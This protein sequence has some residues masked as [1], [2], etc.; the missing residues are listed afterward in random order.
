VKPCRALA[1]LRVQ[2][3]CNWAHQFLI[4]Y[5]PRRSVG[6]CQSGFFC[7]LEVWVHLVGCIDIQGEL[8][9][10]GAFLGVAPGHEKELTPCLSPTLQFA[11][12]SP[13]TNLSNCK[14]N[15]AAIWRVLPR[16]ENGGARM[17]CQVL[18]YPGCGSRQPNHPAAGAGRL[19]QA[20]VRRLQS[21]ALFLIIKSCYL[22]SNLTASSTFHPSGLLGEV[23]CGR[24]SF[25]AT[26]ASFP[27]PVFS[28]SGP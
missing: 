4:R 12:P 21:P 1:E 9:T 14:V 7:C 8:G 17:V 20:P 13:G 28:P 25:H 2:Q 3:A 24:P 5:N 19:P 26:A 23:R 18:P 15:V 27:A 16:V 6:P 10:A 11:T 22:G